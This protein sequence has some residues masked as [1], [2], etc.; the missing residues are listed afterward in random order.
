MPY[1]MVDTVKVP[2]EVGTYILS[3]RWV[4]VPNPQSW[5]GSGVLSAAVL[6]TERAWLWQDCEQTPQ[7]W[8]SC[9]DL[10]IV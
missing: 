6:L 5:A 8:N 10:V 7:V 4:R 2:D 1:S 3:W 9:A